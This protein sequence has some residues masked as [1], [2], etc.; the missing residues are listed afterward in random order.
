MQQSQF[1]Y[2]RFVAFAVS[3][4]TERTE[5][6][7]DNLLF[8]GFLT[9]LIIDDAVAGHINTHIGWGFIWAGAID[10]LEHLI[11]DWEDFDVAVVVDGG[12]A[13]RGEVIWVDHIHVV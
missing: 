4:M 10:L 1:L 2:L 13:I 11:K 6:T 3:Q 12:Y 5:I 8:G 9:D 7:T